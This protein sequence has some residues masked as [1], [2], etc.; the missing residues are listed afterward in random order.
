M[1]IKTRST[2]PS[3][4]RAFGARRFWPVLLATGVLAACASPQPNQRLDSA[5]SAYEQAR[6]NTARAEMSAAELDRANA[7]LQRADRAWSK[8]EDRIEVDHLSY[9]AQREVDLAVAAG[10]RREVERTIE[11]SARE[12]DAIQLE[13]SRRRTDTAQAQVSTAQMQA[14]QERQRADQLAARL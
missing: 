12:R 8:G 7:A 2:T 14:E 6:R 4:S 13:A 1:K 9:I 3:S 10:Q 5:R 11:Q